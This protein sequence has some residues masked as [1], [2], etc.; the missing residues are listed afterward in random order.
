VSD[1]GYAAP[2]IGD[3][4]LVVSLKH[5]GSMS[6]DCRERTAEELE[7]LPMHM[8]KAKVCER[9]RAHVRLRVLV[10][11]VELAQKSF[12]PSGIWGD[13]NSVAVERFA[14]EPGEH[15]VSV[16]VGESLDPE[17]WSFTDSRVLEF[18]TEA[19]QVVVFDRLTGFSWY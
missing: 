9:R 11:D 13:G 6:E 18:T 10:D 14:M 17:E 12:P 2:A 1:L 16:A 4:E 3:S 15:R 19:R 5:P 8:R 7:A